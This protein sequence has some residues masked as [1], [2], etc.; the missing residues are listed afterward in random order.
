[1]AEHMVGIDDLDVVIDLDVPGRDHALALLAQ[2]QSGFVQVMHADG[3]VLE[4]QQD[5]DD[6]LLQAFQGRVL[7][8]HAVDFDFGDGRTRNRRQQ[9]AAQRV[10][11]GVTETAF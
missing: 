7:V 10:A 5:F 4:V 6:V 9:N 2:G 11:Q 3:D 1:M 8:Q